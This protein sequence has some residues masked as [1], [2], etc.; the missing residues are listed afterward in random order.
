MALIR[1]GHSRV[2]E[3]GYSL[4][5]TAQEELAQHKQQQIVDLAYAHR[6]SKST[7]DHWKKFVKDNTPK[8]ISPNTSKEKPKKKVM[9]KEDHMKVIRRLKGL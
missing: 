6:V 4:F 2:Y 7:D 8:E 5:Q 1:N 3:Y 9:T